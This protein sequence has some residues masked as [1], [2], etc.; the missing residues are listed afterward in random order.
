MQ[1]QILIL[2]FTHF[3]WQGFYKITLDGSKA[4]DIPLFNQVEKNLALTLFQGQ[5]VLSLPIL[6]RN[7]KPSRGHS[8]DRINIVF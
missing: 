1:S 5:D 3:G 6:P 8:H 2:D 4:C 7:R